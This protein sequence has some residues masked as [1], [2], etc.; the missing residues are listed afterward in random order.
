MQTPFAESDPTFSPDGKWLAYTSNE[1]G[2]TEVH[3]QP[4][5]S[6]GGK[7]QV[8]RAGGLEPSWRGDGR[9]L[10]YLA[11]GGAMMA[12]PIESGK[13]FQFGTP[14]RL[15]ETAITSTQ[16]NNPYVVARDGQRFLIPVADRTEAPPITVLTNWM[17]GRSR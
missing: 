5:P 14:Q 10:F 15:F 2:R 3:V 4:F 16:N 17:A 8:S 13:D 12:V 6:G 9:E 7:Y 11:P 1:S